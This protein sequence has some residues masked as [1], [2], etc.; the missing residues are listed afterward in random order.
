MVRHRSS[1]APLAWLYAG[2]IVYASLYPFSGW[3]APGVAPLAF[4]VQ[5]W[6]PW[7]T[8]FDLVANLLGYLPLGMLM[9]V[10][11]V[12]SGRTARTSVLTA[13]LV[14]ALLSLAME[15]TQN[16]L[17]Q[18]VSS[19]V[20]LGLNAV[21]CLA[22][23]LLGALWHWLGGVTRWQELRDRWFIAGSAGGLALLVLWPVA[24]L[25]PP[26]APLAPGQVL[27]R[28]HELLTDLLQGTPAAAWLQPWL[29][30]EPRFA[31]LAPSAEFAATAL[32]LLAPC[33]LAFSVARPGWR[34]L[35]LVAGATVFGLATTTLSTALNFGPQHAFAWR[36]PTALVAIAA[37]AV[38]ASALAPFPRRTAAALGLMTLTAL[39][40]LVAQAPADAYRA[41]SLQAWEQGRFVRFHGAA[42]WV[43]WLWPYV[44]L[45]YLFTRVGIA[46]DGPRGRG[47]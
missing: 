8:G 18:R 17:P 37:A 40:V 23:A 41:A 9:V 16:W 39:I 12:R 11:G 10:A 13:T 24:L 20:D 7:W 43:G 29:G 28:L 5:P 19:N 6:S 31:P 3:R 25:F 35:A 26:P 46:E 33:L 4:L 36:T 32:G 34:R 15:T 38:V 44:T 14:G 21:G 1:A 2:L 30:T 42:R 47:S 27:Q 22:G 45:A